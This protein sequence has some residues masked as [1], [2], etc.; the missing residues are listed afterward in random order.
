VAVPRKN[1]ALLIYNKRHHVKQLGG[2]GNHRLIV[3]K[4]Q[5]HMM[6]TPPKGITGMVAGAACLQRVSGTGYFIDPCS[7]AAGRLLI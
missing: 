2:Y 4:G 7:D 3:S 1:T 5:Q 6:R